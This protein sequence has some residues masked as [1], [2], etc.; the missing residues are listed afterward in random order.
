MIM[1]QADGAISIFDPELMYSA[2]V[3]VY[4]C[5]ASKSTKKK[6][7]EMVKWYEEGINVSKPSNTNKFLVVFEDGTIYTFYKENPDT[8]ENNRST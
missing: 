7:V 1:G 3:S 2:N 8:T 5:S 4:N 6:K